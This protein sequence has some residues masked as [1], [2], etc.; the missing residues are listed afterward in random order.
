MVNSCP[1]EGDPRLSVER[2][3]IDDS[4][5]SMGGLRSE[6]LDSLMDTVEGE[7]MRIYPDTN[8]IRL[9]RDVT[10]KIIKSDE[11]IGFLQDSISLDGRDAIIVREDLP[12]IGWQEALSILSVRTGVPVYFGFIGCRQIPACGKMM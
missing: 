2:F 11:L 10:S 12:I 1:T 5:R 3:I 4:M 6:G 7:I 8:I 9:D